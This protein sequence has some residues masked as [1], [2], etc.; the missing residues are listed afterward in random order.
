MEGFRGLQRSPAFGR[1]EHPQAAPCGRGSPPCEHCLPRRAQAQLV[2][3]LGAIVRNQAPSGR[4]SVLEA[5]GEVLLRGWRAAAGACLF[6]VE[7]LIQVRTACLAVDH[8]W[9]RS[10]FATSAHTAQSSWHLGGA[11]SCLVSKP[12]PWRSTCMLRHGFR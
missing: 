9:L 7:A 6:E 5:Y 8:A 10:L 11:P 3:E 1:C 12:L 2:R 4:A